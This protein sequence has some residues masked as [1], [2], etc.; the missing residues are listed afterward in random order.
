M[1]STHLLI[2]CLYLMIAIVHTLSSRR[3]GKQKLRCLYGLSKN[4]SYTTYAI[5]A[6]NY[7]RVA[8]SIN[9]GIKIQSSLSVQ[10]G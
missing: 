7:A 5:Q 8:R 2:R 10:V 6:C 4:S 3:S 1:S 9:D